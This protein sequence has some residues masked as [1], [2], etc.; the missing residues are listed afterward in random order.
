VAEAAES[1]AAV[2]AADSAPQ[3]EASTRTLLVVDCS[4]VD[5]VTLAAALAL[6]RYDAGQRHR[7]GGL[8]LEGAFDPATAEEEAT[9]LRAAGL[10]VFLIPE[11]LAR[12]EPWLAV[13]GVREKDGLSL[14]GAPGSRRVVS[15][16]L[17]LVVRGPIVR[18]YQSPLAPRKVHTARPEGGYRFHLHLRS[19]PQ[20][21]ELDPGDFDFGARP[22]IF[23]SSLLEMND[24]LESLVQGAVVDDAFRLATPAL[25]PSAA[26]AG[27]LAATSAL[28]R[29][30]KGRDKGQA[31]IHD[32]LRQFRFYSAWRGAVE[33]ARE[34]TA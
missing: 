34:Q 4:S 21:L 16:D 20:A 9:R 24:W 31:T 18:E 8:A 10:V 25:G 22:A 29:G 12:A 3:G 33:R 19:S 30:G 13:A 17:L 2:A 32:N 11:A 28:S 27:P 26:P 6:T 5:A 14:R 7:R 15:S 1:A 23:G